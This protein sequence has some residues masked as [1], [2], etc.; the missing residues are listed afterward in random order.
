MANQARGRRAFSSARIAGGTY[1]LG[2]AVCIFLAFDFEG[3]INLGWTLALIVLTLPASAISLPLSWALIHGAD[4][5]FFAVMY[6]LFAVTNVTAVRWLL[7]RRKKVA[8]R[9]P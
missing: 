4:L 2:V 3:A 8:T 5:E 9:I 6:F 7:R 1:L